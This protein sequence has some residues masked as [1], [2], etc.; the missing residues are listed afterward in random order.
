[1]KSPIQ[2]LIL[3]GL[4]FLSQCN[5]IEDWKQKLYGDYHK[6]VAPAGELTDERVQNY[7]N[8]VKKLHKLGPK[9]PQKI[10]ESKNNQVGK[11]DLY[12]EIDQ[13]VK[14]EGFTD[15][16]DFVRINAKVAWAWNISQGH[17][18]MD[19]FQKMNDNGIKQIDEALK[20][21]NLPQETRQELLKAK[22][23]IQKNWNHNKKYADISLNFVKPLTN[24]NDLTMIKKYQKELMEAYT[25][26]PIDQ[27]K[28]IDP[29][30]FLNQK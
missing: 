14:D 28:E 8:A 24:Q 29:D 10:A 16:F 30:I 11:V 12:N 9:L 20:T 1:M 7:I 3:S 23:E 13:L 17:I 19:K 2:L 4:I 5:L 25:S 22:E 27:L 18:A 26:I 15:Y 21:P 6:V